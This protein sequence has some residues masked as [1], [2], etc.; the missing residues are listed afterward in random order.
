MTKN[1]IIKLIESLKSEGLLT[2]SPGNEIVFNRFKNSN[3]KNEIIKFI[4]SSGEP[5]ATQQCSECKENLSADQFSYYQA[6][7]DNKGYLSRTNALCQMCA[8]KLNK[9]RRD[10]FKKDKANIPKKPVPGTRCPHCKRA[11]SHSWHKHHSYE[12]GEFKAW[13][14]GN[15]NMA[16]QDR[17][18]PRNKDAK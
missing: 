8:K 12:T 7:V 18:N 16:L 17:R 15:C 11:W 3:D 5:S 4:L 13:I 6:R 10:A 9:D 1:E 2:R 14:C